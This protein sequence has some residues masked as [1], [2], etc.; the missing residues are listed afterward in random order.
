MSAARAYV[1]AESLW[2][3]AEKEAVSALNRYAATHSE[4]DFRLYLLAIAVPLGDRR[5]REELEKP[6]PESRRRAPG[7]SRRTQRSRR[8]RRNDH[9]VPALPER[10]VHGPDHR[11]LDAKPMARSRRWSG[12]G[13][14]DARA[15][16]LRQPGPRCP[17]ADI[18][19]DRRDRRAPDAA[20]EFVLVH[21]GRRVARDAARCCRSSCWR[22]P[23][24]S[25]CSAPS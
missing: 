7:L 23:R 18:E 14:E 8:H 5:A 1:G 24:C 15:G 20:R 16:A 2:S 19:R 9:A 3:K 6:E 11:D 4:R 21:A 25:S 17:A 13:P 12:R 22:S 10:D